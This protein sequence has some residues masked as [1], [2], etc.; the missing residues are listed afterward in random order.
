MIAFIA[1]AMLAVSS[2][3]TEFERDGFRLC[4]TF[5]EMAE[6]IMSVRQA[7]APMSE[8]IALFDGASPMVARIGHELVIK[9]Y[10]LPVYHVDEI[11]R[12]QAKD[13]AAEAATVCYRAVLEEADKLEGANG[14]RS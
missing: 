8:V 6:S 1:S 4:A 11:D 14:S 3:S 13:F 9:A 10:T 12:Q 2:P 5:E 7:G